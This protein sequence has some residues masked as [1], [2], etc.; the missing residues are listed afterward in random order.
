MKLITQIP[1][2][3]LAWYHAHHRILP[4]RDP[5]VPYHTWVSEI[6]LQQTRVDAVIDYYHR[7]LTA[8]PTIADLADAP[9]EQLLKLWEG[10]GYYNRVRNLQKAAR[11]VVAEHD[12]V[13]PAD[14][15]MLQTLPG[16]GKYTAGAIASIAFGIPVPAVDGNVLRVISR[17]VGSRE[18]ISKAST[19]SAMETEL[20]AVMAQPPAV[21]QAGDFVQALME[22]GALICVP[23]GAPKC[24]TCPLQSFCVAHH[25]N[26]TDQIPV[27]DEKKARTLEQK[28]VLVL[29]HGDRF[30]LQKRPDKGLLAS[31][32]EFPSCAGKLKKAEVLALPYDIQSVR[33]LGAGKHIFTHIEWKMTGFLLKVDSLDPAFTWVTAEELEKDFALPSAFDSYRQ[34]TTQLC[35]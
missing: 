10:L 25:E 2:P 24:A 16:I 20:L 35:D 6:M 28:T 14:Y 21:D 23:N 12:G 27:K 4:W 8:L 19:K 34:I 26:L 30:A 29:Q 5:I 22:L 13:L 31:M 18:N 9:E 33:S 15:Q 7:F 17:V 3:L 11:V 32:W 1:T